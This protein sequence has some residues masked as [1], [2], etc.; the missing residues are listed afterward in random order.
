MSVQYILDASVVLAVIKGEPGEA[1]K[2]FFERSAILSVN[3]TEVISK[4]LRLGY[5]ETQAN[6]AFDILQLDIQPFDK[7]LVK[8]AAAL[9]KLSPGFPLSLGDRACLSLAVHNNLPVLTADRAWTDLMLPIE[10]K[11]IR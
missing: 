10:V 5:S 6:Q 3:A 8:I 4:L 1:A 2:C 9:T 7:P 11:L